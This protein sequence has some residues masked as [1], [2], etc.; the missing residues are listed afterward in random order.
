M[1]RPGGRLALAVWGGLPRNPFFAALGTTLV[2][3]GHLP[4]PDPSAPGPFSLAGPDRVRGLL[5]AAGFADVRAEEVAV[6]FVLRD[7]DE[8]V[9]ISADTSG[10][11][12]LVLQGL[13]E[14][15]RAHVTESLGAA[16]APFRSGA[17]YEVPGLAVVAVAA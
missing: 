13:E 3:A 16:L 6:R 17:R 14:A 2:Q 11:M 5:E 7:V 1:L 10:P 4:P 8:Y 9:A 15:E 12:A